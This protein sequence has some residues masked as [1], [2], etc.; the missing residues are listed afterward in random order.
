MYVE[1][2]LCVD[3]E[4][5]KTYPQRNC[6]LWSA[7]NIGWEGTS[8]NIVGEKAIAIDTSIAMASITNRI[9]IWSFW[10]TYHRLFLE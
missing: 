3:E 8:C 2:F 4:T 5:T 1:Y 7:K 6:L 10:D 9:K